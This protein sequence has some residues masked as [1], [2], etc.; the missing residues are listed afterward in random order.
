MRSRHGMGN[1][2]LHSPLRSAVH[3][4]N[5]QKQV[6]FCQVCVGCTWL[7]GESR[8]PALGAAGAPGQADWGRVRR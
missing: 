8:L 4:S 3:L 5:A 6:V 2:K 1:S 7:P